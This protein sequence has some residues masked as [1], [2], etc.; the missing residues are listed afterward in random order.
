MVRCCVYVY[1][2]RFLGVTIEQEKYLVLRWYRV[3]LRLIFL[4]FFHLNTRDEMN[5]QYI[6]IYNKIYKYINIYY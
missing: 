6:N 4:V 1:L 5:V 2:S 3:I